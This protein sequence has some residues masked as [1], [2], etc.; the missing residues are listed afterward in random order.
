MGPHSNMTFCQVFQI[1]PVWLQL[2]QTQVTEFEAS[3]SQ[4][5]HC[6][7]SEMNGS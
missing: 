7:H 2:P 1:S 6:I 4:T 5:Q 3:P